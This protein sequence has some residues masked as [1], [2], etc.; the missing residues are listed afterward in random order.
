MKNLLLL[1]AI[2]GLTASC[3]S[4]NPGSMRNR[5][6]ANRETMQ[7]FYDEV[8]NAHNPAMI[9]SFCTADFIDH[10]AD[11]RYPAGMEGLRA[12]FTDFF[13]AYPDLHVKTNFVVAKGDTVFAQFTMTGTNSGSMMGMPATN[14]QITIDGI[15]AI[16]LKDG[17]AIEHWGYQEEGKLMTQLGMMPGSGAPADSTMTGDNAPKK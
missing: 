14:K 4:K 12:A 6:A 16:I 9:D 8:M 3:G 7:R 10:Q 5:N 17:K 15:D 11:P 13:A 2:A 1:I